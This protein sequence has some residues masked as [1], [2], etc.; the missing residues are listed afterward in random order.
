MPGENL[1]RG[2]FVIGLS[3]TNPTRGLFENGTFLFFV[4]FLSLS[5]FFFKRRPEMFFDAPKNIEEE[6]TKK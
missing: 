4:Y 5:D 1:R 6:N 3:L 2:G